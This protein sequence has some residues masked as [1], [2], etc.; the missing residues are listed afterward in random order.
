MYAIRSY[1]VIDGE[2]AYTGSQNLVDPRYF[3]QKT[4]VGEWVDVMARITGPV[5]ELLQVIF[6]FDR[7]LEE[8]KQLYDSSI[9]EELHPV[10]QRGRALV[11]LASYNFV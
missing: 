5:T 6:F 7:L 4:G 2:I 9:A 8:G 10:P 11:Q 1:Y 3:K